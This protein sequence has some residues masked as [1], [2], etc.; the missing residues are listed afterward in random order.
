MEF[1]SDKIKGTI[2]VPQNNNVYNYKTIPRRVKYLYSF[3]V[4]RH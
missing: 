1:G 2:T 3:Y 4:Q